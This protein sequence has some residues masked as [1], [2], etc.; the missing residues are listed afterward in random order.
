M[1][2]IDTFAFGVQLHDVNK[3]TVA[4]VAYEVKRHFTDWSMDEILALAF[5]TAKRRIRLGKG[6]V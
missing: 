4:A 5:C 1:L 6:R 3:S 2:K